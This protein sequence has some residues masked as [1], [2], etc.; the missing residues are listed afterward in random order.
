VI[1]VKSAASASAGGKVLNKTSYGTDHQVT[2]FKATSKSLQQGAQ[3]AQ[4]DSHDTGKAAS[5]AGLPDVV[6]V[7]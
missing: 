3:I 2:G 1:E 7:P 4:Q 5:G 6:S